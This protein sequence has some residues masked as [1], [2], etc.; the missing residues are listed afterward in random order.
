MEIFIAYTYE[1]ISKKAANDV[2]EIMRSFKNPL[3]C[4]ASGDT[5]A[6]LYKEIV[7]KVNKNELD[8]SDWSFV[9]LDEW[10][11][12]NETDEGSCQFHLNNQLFHPLQIAK[13]KICFFDGR[14]K[15][16]N[17]ECEDVESFILQYGGINVSILGL[18]MNGHIGM[19]EPGTSPSLRSHVTALEPITQKVG[20]KYF[21]E[22][23][24]LTEGIT[25]GLATLMESKHIILLISG[26]HKAE[27][28]R[29]L[30][31]KEISKQLPAS[32]LRNHSGLKIYLD[33]AAA[34]LTPFLA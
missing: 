21:K 32:L 15:D 5:P 3:L 9:G 28:V 30:I 25:L 10:I 23:Q 14:A 16:L 33:K 12:L 24:Q 17:K 18:G 22:Q 7:D 1:G 19:N 34:Q 29:R 13:S 8:S 2:I 6:G 31:K 26:S 11:G 20:Q 4:V 27:I